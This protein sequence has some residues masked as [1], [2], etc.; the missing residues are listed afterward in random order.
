MQLF[1]VSF[2]RSDFLQNPYF[3]NGSLSTKIIS[4]AELW[5]QKQTDFFFYVCWHFFSAFQSQ[6]WCGE[7]IM[8]A[9]S[10][11]WCACIH[12]VH[13]ELKYDLNS[14]LDFKKK[15]VIAILLFAWMVL[16]YVLPEITKAKKYKFAFESIKPFTHRAIICIKCNER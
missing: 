16:K 9:C 15:S 12:K 8:H 3:N 5:W 11:K 7:D 14:H 10:I 1:R 2:F 4:H 13:N 6:M